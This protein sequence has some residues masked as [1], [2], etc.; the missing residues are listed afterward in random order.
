[1]KA[2]MEFHVEW[3]IPDAED[4]ASNGKEPDKEPQKQAPALAAAQDTVKT[5][6][7]AK[8]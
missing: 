3:A 4:R 2:K 6:L 5:A 7:S 8:A 1:M